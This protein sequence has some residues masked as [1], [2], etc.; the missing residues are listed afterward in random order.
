MSASPQ[1]MHSDAAIAWDDLALELSQINPLQSSSIATALVALL[2]RHLGTTRT[3]L[4]F[5]NGDEGEI[6]D[7]VSTEVTKVDGDKAHSSDLVDSVRLQGTPLFVYDATSDESAGKRRTYKTCGYAVIP[8]CHAGA[9]FAVLCISNLSSQQVMQLEN[10]GKPFALAMAQIEQLALLAAGAAPLSS[11]T[12]LEVDELSLL[13]LIAEKLDSEIEA[14]SVFGRFVDL[15]QPLIPLDM[16]GII[17]AQEDSVPRGVICLQR[18]AQRSSLES[19]FNDIAQ[20]WQRRKR[21]KVAL[22]L[23]DAKLYGEELVQSGGMRSGKTEFG[24]CEVIPLFVDNDLFAIVSIAAAPHVMSDRRRMRL[25]A[26]L[27]HQLMV[28]VKKN[29]LIERNSSLQ[30]LDALTG[31]YNERHFYQQLEREFDRA[32]RYKVPLSM[33]IFDV[34][35]FKDVNE[36]YGFETG[37]QLLREVSRILMENVRTTDFVCRYG[38]ERFL[39]L[40]PETHGKNAELLAN[41][42]RRYIENFSFFIPNTNVFIKVT[43]SAGVAS[44][45]EHKPASV[46]QFIEFADSALYFAKRNGRNQVVSY[47]YVMNLMLGENGHNG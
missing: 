2:A 18:S 7:V 35:H 24:R 15:V 47:S 46:A 38:G 34:D 45:L 12:G 23:S 36:A 1:R 32:N 29:E 22:T 10:G 28:Y 26:Y 9:C 20:Q 11:Q 41:R 27:L 8:L 3:S 25:L 37:D 4:V 43:V 17:Y 14:R 33:H 30:T 21:H 19:V 39:L 42:L 16:L 40:L 6:G 31:L 44:F 13:A 5:F